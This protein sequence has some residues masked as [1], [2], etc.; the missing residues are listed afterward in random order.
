MGQGYLLTS[1]D[2]GEKG[3][4]RGGEVERD[5]GAAA[6]AAHAPVGLLR[7]HVQSH[8]RRGDLL[9]GVVSRGKLVESR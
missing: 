3:E 7:R 6:A 5:G 1:R 4:G 2:G 9:V 8:G